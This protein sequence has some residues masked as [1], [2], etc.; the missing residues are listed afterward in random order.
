M[1]CGMAVI[2]FDSRGT[3]FGTNMAVNTWHVTVPGA[4]LTSEANAIV[5]AVNT[6]YNG[7]STY[8]AISYTTGTRVL[9]FLESW[10]TKPVKDP[11]THKVTTRGFFHTPPTIVPATSA[12]S[13]AGTGQS[14]PA[15]LASVVSWRTATSGRSGRG[16]TYLGG[17]NT[18]GQSTAVVAAAAVT[19]INTAAST[20]ISAIAAV[21]TGGGNAALAIWSPTLGTTLPVLSGASDATFDT[22]RSRVK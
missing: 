20:L 7:W 12:T 18:T 21:S 2:S 22:M 3:L 4:L 6:F 11:V 10:W 19:A 1:V 14:I 8:R 13:S 5:N 17:F 9:Y 16:R 15:Q